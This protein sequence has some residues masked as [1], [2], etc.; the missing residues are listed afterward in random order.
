M[1]KKKRLRKMIEDTEATWD[2]IV[3]AGI[4]TLAKAAKKGKK[5]RFGK[6]VKRGKK[7]LDLEL[8]E[9]E[10]IVFAPEEIEIAYAPTGNG[11]YEVDV[12]GIVVERVQG[13]EAAAGR[14]GELLQAHAS[15]ADGKQA[16]SE[17]GILDVGGGWYDV[18]VSGVPVEKVRGM[19]AAEE[20]MAEVRAFNE[21]SSEDE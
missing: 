6:A 19:E 21:G 2:D 12:N 8:P 20:R 16:T 10:S 11:W 7:T 3:H 4:G 15:L 5:K 18:V 17:T 13:E 1:G 9:L 14:A